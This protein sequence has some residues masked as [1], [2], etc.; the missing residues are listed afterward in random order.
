[1]AL[2][3]V[4]G[5]S[6][7]IIFQE[8]DNLPKSQ[9][10]DDLLSIPSPGTKQTNDHRPALKL[11]ATTMQGIFRCAQQQFS[12]KSSNLRFFKGSDTELPLC[13]HSADEFMLSHEPLSPFLRDSVD[14]DAYGSS[15]SESEKKED[16]L[17]SSSEFFDN[18]SSNIPEESPRDSHSPTSEQ[19]NESDIVADSLASQ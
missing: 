11:P 5:V 15:G 18:E 4:P 12:A 10:D 6:S 17:K 2:D 19:D 8:A 14:S 9:R 3:V 7:S 1:M 13:Y 16:P